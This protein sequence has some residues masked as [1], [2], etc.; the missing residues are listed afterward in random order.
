MSVEGV[1]KVF[2]VDHA[3]CSGDIST[4]NCP[5]PQED[6]EF[7]SYCGI[8]RTGVYGCKPLGP[9]GEPVDTQYDPPVNCTGNALGDTPVSVVNGTRP[10][11]CTRQPVCT[12]DIIG[13]CPVAQDGLPVASVCQ[14]IPTGVYGCVV[15]R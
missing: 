11:Y 10:G 14:L 6:L 12:A 15:P 7:G 9:D 2:C 3:A 1:V 13:N 5:G 8:V 4:G